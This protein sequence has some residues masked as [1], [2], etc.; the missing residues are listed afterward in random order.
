MEQRPTSRSCGPCN[1]CCKPFIVPEVEKLDG[2]WCKHCIIGK[3]WNIYANRPYACRAF[4]CI[5]LNGKGAE[6]DRPDRLGVFFDVEDFTIGKRAVGILHVY[7]IEEGATDHPRVQQILEVNLD[8][9]F[10]VFGHLAEGDAYNTR[11]RMRKE[12]FTEEETRVF[13]ESYDKVRQSRRSRV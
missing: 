9:G 13:T 7:E 8:A 10:I 2:R 12:L 5:W 1:A 6:G 3:G 11:I 4:A